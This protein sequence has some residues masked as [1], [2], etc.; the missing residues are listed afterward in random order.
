MA[1]PIFS[2][3]DY[4]NDMSRAS[5]H[6]ADANALHGYDPVLRDSADKPLE[7]GAASVNAI[8]HALTSAYLAYDHSTTEAAALGLARE[9]K[10]YF[11][12]QPPEAWDT[13]KDLYNNQAGRNIA[14]YARKNNLPREQI[15]DLILDALSSGRLIATRQDPRI[16]RSFNGNPL[17][18][19]APSGDAAPWTAPSPGFGDYAATITRVPVGPAGAPRGPS[20]PGKRGALEPDPA[21][22]GAAFADAS[23]AAPGGLPGLI[24]SII[25]PDPSDPIGVR[26]P[27]GGLPGLIQDYIRQQ[28]DGPN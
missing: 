22:S 11:G 3:Q 14:D 5:E 6:L 15:Q 4:L 13:F 27:A 18:F 16:A 2:F 28:T 25:G 23:A 19:T 21:S 9:L 8:A 12:K 7:L 10:S 17:K 26:V 24:A 1:D 20:V